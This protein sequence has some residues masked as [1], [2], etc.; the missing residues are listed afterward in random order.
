M[1]LIDA[2]TIWEPHASLV[3]I[4]AKQYETRG[5]IPK[6][7]GRWIAIH[8]AKKFTAEIDQVCRQ[9]PIRTLLRRAG[10]ERPSQL[11]CGKVVAVAWLEWVHRTEAIRDKIPAHELAIG[12]YAHGRYAWEFQKL[13]RIKDPIPAIGCQGIW[14]WDAPED[15]LKRMGI[16]P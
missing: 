11:N 4:G 15:L 13:K 7:A 12:D 5:W 3:A 9:E 2:L 6:R 16:A 10:I 1:P 14:K 8:A